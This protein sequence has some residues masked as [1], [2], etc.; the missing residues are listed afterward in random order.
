MAPLMP[1]FGWQPVVLTTNS[2]GD[3]PLLLPENNIIRIGENCDSKKV[4]VS[5]EREK[6]IPLYLK[7][8]YWF[9]RKQNIEIKSIDRF[10]FSWGRE[11]LKKEKLI[12]EINPDAIIATYL[13]AVDIWLGYLLARK[14]KKPWLAEFRDASSLYNVSG[15]VITRFLDRQIDKFLVRSAAAVITIGPYL[16]Q[17]LGGLY[18]RPVEIVYHGFSEKTENSYEQKGKKNI[19]YYAGRFHTHRLAAV[20]LL[21]DWLA[22]DRE[23]GFYFVAR[24]LGPK[25]ANE[26]ITA[27]AKKKGVADRVALLSPAS[28]EIIEKE[29]GEAA[30]LILFEDLNKELGVI[31]R[32]TMTGKFFEYL[33]KRAPVVAINREDSD[34]GRILEQTKRGYL[35]SGLGQ[36]DI[37]IKNIIKGNGLNPDWQ[38][39]KEFSRE[40]QTKKLCQLLD[41]I[42]RKK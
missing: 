34:L 17:A 6:G 3:L 2:Q 20:R 30:V 5:E 31:S 33:P 36:L 32:G 10:L 29:E 25:E 41:R 39:I 14:L 9:L 22:S 21:I 26:E 42:V 23:S 18:G 38:K 24:S 12:R 4:L 40:E 16:A 7:P 8:F 28:P 27:Y 15:S 37:A 1:G 11:V 35:V 13:P 19:I